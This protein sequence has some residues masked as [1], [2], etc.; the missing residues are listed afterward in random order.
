MKII[1]LQDVPKIGRRHEVK[2]VASGYASNFLIPR[3]LATPAT[4]KK[5]KALEEQ[6]KRSQDETEVQRALLKKSLEKL[7]KQTITI[8]TR[9]NE[10]GHLFKSI[11][12]KDILSAIEKEIGCRFPE[13]S[14]ELQEILKTVGKFPLKAVIG[15][16]GASFTLVVTSS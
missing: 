13:G 11:H 6:K 5:I 15:E 3:D 12:E 4:T 14:I 16:D 1:L 9:A 10:Q 8:A 7:N 2:E